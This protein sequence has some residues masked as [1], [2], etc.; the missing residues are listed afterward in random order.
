MSLANPPWGA[1]RIHGELL[2]LG[3]VV[4]QTLGRQVH[5]KAQETP[6]SRLQDV[7]EAIFDPIFE[8]RTAF[9]FGVVDRLE[10][11]SVAPGATDA[12]RGA[13]SGGLDQARISDARYEVDMAWIFLN[14]NGR[15]GPLMS[16]VGPTPAILPAWVELGLWVEGGDSNLDA[17]GTSS[18]AL[19]TLASDAAAAPGQCGPGQRARRPTKSRRV[20]ISGRAPNSL[21]RDSNSLIGIKF[22]SQIPCKFAS[23]ILQKDH[24]ISAL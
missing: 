21:L 22:G 1:P 9:V 5:G 23:G 4:G 7:I 16:P 24:A 13:A 19:R 18:K 20:G 3:I 14:P 12:F 11:F 6:L 15:I 8:V 2:K 17:N 10:E